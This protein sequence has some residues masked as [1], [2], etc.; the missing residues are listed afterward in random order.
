[1]YPASLTKIATAIYAIENRKLNDVVTISK[2]ARN[3]EGTR[4]YLEEGEQVTLEKLLLGLLVN[5]GNECRR[6]HC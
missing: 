3:T 1:M 6:R 4:V 2:K 5:S